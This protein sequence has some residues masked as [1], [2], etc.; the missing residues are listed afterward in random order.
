SLAVTVVDVG[1]TT[2]IGSLS[3]GKSNLQNAGLVYFYPYNPTDPQS[4]SADPIFT[5]S[6]Q[7][8]NGSGFITLLLNG[9]SS[10]LFQSA[11]PGNTSGLPLATGPGLSSVPEPAAL[12]LAL[13]GGV[14]LLFG[15]RRRRV[16]C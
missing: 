12:P 15:A 4:A 8:P 14:A 10:E 1:G 13:V 6:A 2:T 3:Y 9:S 11:T 5:L 16:H 7:N